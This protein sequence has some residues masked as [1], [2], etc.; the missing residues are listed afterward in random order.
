MFIFFKY[1]SIIVNPMWLSYRNYFVNV[2]YSGWSRWG[3]VGGC[4]HQNHA[5]SHSQQ[6][7]III[8]K[9]R[10]PQESNPQTRATRGYNKNKGTGWFISPLHSICLTYEIARLKFNTLEDLH[11]ISRSIFSS[12]FICIIYKYNLCYSHNKHLRYCSNI[13]DHFSPF[14]IHVGYTLDR[15][16]L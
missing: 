10:L 8:V 3:N 1:S 13:I 14:L 9:F 6:T 2:S 11:L 4:K 12:A 5:H 16:Q 7:V 15:V